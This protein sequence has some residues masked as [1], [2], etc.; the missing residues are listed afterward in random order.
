M[1]EHEEM[2][3]FKRTDSVELRSIKEFHKENL[4]YILD[5]ER[6]I[7]VGISTKDNFKNRLYHHKRE[8]AK[9]G[10][11]LIEGASKVIK[12][13]SKQE[14]KFL[15]SIIKTNFDTSLVCKELEL[16]GY[17]EIFPISH[18]EEIEETLKYFWY[19]AIFKP[20]YEWFGIE[21]SEYEKEKANFLKNIF[22]YF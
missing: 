5:F 10:C 2:L 18:K 11:S 17:T 3:F 21:I 19:N 4:I 12:C 6:F 14:A 9:I 1:N 16:N 13:D 15:E 20:K 22:E 8:F 7:K